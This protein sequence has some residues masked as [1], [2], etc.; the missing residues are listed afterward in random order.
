MTVDEITEAIERMRSLLA[1]ERQT[2]RRLRREERLRLTL[3]E[4][5]ERGIALRDL[6]VDETDA[7]I[8]GRVLLWLKPRGAVGFGDLRFHIGE[9]VRLWARDPEGE[10]VEPA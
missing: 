4:R 1:R 2:T 8:G 9:P 7:A 3:A 10:D 6:M 5:V